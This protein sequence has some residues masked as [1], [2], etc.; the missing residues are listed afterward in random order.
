MN[1]YMMIRRVRG[2]AFLLLVGVNALLA[3]RGILGWGQ[4]WPFFLILAGLL[5][6][7]ERA[8]LAWDGYP[9]VPGAPWCGPGPGM[10][11]QPQQGASSSAPAAGTG[12]GTNAGVPPASAGPV[13]GQGTGQSTEQGSGQGSGQGVAYRSP[14]ISG[15][16]VPPQW[17]EFNDEKKG[18]QS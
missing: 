16:I 18:G 3:Q 8:A 10:G 17:Q 9:P 12:P 13:T 5:M 1:R 7:A 14:E 2:P 15:A 6:L 11:Q 4:S